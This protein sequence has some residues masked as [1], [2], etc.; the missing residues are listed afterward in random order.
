MLTVFNRH[1]GFYL[2]PNGQN[3]YLPQIFNQLGAQQVRG[4]NLVS[5]SSLLK[6]D[7]RL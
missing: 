2:I 7:A 4:Q 3:N 6:A 5:K 1:A